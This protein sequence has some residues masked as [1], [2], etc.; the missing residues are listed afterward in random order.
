MYTLFTT[1]RSV[2]HLPLPYQRDSDDESTMTLLL[3]DAVKSPFTLP[4]P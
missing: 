3:Q 4:P 2:L 1:S